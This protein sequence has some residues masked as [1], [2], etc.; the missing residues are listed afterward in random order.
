VD[1]CGIRRGP[2]SCKF[3]FLLVCCIPL[4]R[5]IVTTL[6]VSV[7]VCKFAGQGV[8]L[9]SVKKITSKTKASNSKSVTSEVVTGNVQPSLRD[10]VDLS[11]DMNR[12]AGFDKHF[13][14][15]FN[16]IDSTFS[17]SLL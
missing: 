4:D 11:Q 7:G 15:V 12:K 5:P 2:T 9:K 6:P 3:S 13:M 1:G 10:F 14:S 8:G 17:V 16:N